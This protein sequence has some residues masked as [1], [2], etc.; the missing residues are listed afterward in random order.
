[1]LNITKENLA[2]FLKKFNFDIYETNNG[3]LCLFDGNTGEIISE[4]GDEE[5]LIADIN[6]K[7]SPMMMLGEEA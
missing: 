1:M 5:N 3:Q 6:C 4:E 2:N 7:M